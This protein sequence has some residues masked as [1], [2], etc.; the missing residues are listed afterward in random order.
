MI[1]YFQDKREKYISEANHTI[2]ELIKTERNYVDHDLDHLVAGFIAYMERS[3]IKPTP[4]GYAPMPEGLSSGRDK[5]AFA[6]LKDLLS[7]HKT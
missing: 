7:F 5:I 3:K 6:N 1:V 2:E 4:K